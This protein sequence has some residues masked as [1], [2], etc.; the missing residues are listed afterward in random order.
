MKLRKDDGSELKK[1][2]YEIDCGDK[3][4]VLEAD[5]EELKIYA[6]IMSEKIRPFISQNILQHAEIHL[7]KRRLQLLGIPKEELFWAKDEVKDKPYVSIAHFDRTCIEKIQKETQEAA[8]E[9]ATIY[10]CPV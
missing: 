3:F 10:M 8:G 9:N 7:L 6:T 4:F 5:E 2:E 1:G